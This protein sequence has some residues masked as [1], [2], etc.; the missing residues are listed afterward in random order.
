MGLFIKVKQAGYLSNNSCGWRQIQDEDIEDYHDGLD[1][2]CYTSQFGRCSVEAFDVIEEVEAKDFDDLDYSGT[3][4]DPTGKEWCDNG[5]IDRDGD[6]YPC[7]W[8]EHDDLAY[9]YFK[10]DVQTLEKSGWIRVMHGVP[11]HETKITQYQYNRCK[12]LGIEISENEV[13]WQ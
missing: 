10:S 4:I 7:G 3:W 1:V 6:I 13:L 2:L 12:E 9:L 5:W 11:K 8:M